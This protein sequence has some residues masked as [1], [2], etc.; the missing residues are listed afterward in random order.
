MQLNVPVLRLKKG[1]SEQQMKTKARKRLT[2]VTFYFICVHLSFEREN[3]FWPI[4]ERVLCCALTFVS[5]L[6]RLLG[7]NKKSC[8]IGCIGTIEG[9]EKTLCDMGN[10]FRQDDIPQIN[11]VPWHS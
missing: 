1:G 5:D 9:V 8:S 4:W 11:F 10:T 7:G 3:Q 2:M 6:W